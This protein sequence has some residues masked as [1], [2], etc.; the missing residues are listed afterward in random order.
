MADVV[1][2]AVRL[3]TPEPVEPLHSS[4]GKRKR[5]PDSRTPSPHRRRPSPPRRRSPFDRE[6]PLRDGRDDGRLDRYPGSRP[7]MQEK[8]APTE[9]EKAEMAKKEFNELISKRSGGVYIP[10][11]KLR[12]L[13]KNIKDPQSKEYQRMMWDA[14][15]KSINGM[16]N[17]VNVGNIKELVPELFNENLIRGRGLFCRSIM[18]A[19]ASYDEISDV[20]AC[21]VAIVNT[22]LPRV[23]ELLVDRLIW[24]WQRAFKR[25]DKAVCISSSSFLAQLANFEVVDHMVVVQVLLTL[26]KQPTDDSIEIAVRV[27]EKIG[28]LLDDSDRTVANALMNDFRKVLQEKSD[29]AVRTQ[30]QL[31]GLFIKRRN[32]FKD[33]PTRREELD[34]IEDEDV[35]KHPGGF[36]RK[37]IDPQDKL[38][39]FQFDPNWEE[40]EQSYRRLRDE[41]LGIEDDSDEEAGEEDEEGEEEDEEDEEEKKMEIK[42]QTNQDLVNLR[43]SIYL[44][45]K[46]SGTFEEAVHKLM[47]INLPV[48][49]EKE[50]PEMIIECASQERTYNTFYG[51]I[52]E[53]FSKLNRLWRSLN[54]ELF[55]EY[56]ESIHRKDSNKTR[57]IANMFAH[58]LATDSISWSVLECVKMNEDETTAASRIFIRILLEE[59]QSAMGIKQLAERL[60]EPELA[61]Y[62]AEI[63]PMDDPKKTRFAI[64]YFTAIKMG[65]LTEGMREFLASIPKPEPQ[66]L[67]EDSYSDSDRSSSYDRYI[68]FSDRSSSRCMINTNWSSESD[69]RSYSDS[70]DS[71]SRSPRRIRRRSPSSDRSRSPESQRTRDRRDDSR[72]PYRSSDRRRRSPSDYSRSPEPRSRRDDS[73]GPSPRRSN[74]RRRYS[75]SR[76]PSP[77]PRRRGNRDDSRS[78]SPYHSN[79]R[80][81]HSESPSRSRS[82][83]PPPPRRHQ[84]YSSSEPASS[85]SPPPRRRYRSESEEDDRPRARNRRDASEEAPPRGGRARRNS[86]SVEAERRRD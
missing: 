81:R 2:S 50:L 56:Y 31:E 15:K 41:I 43:R 6:L 28:R 10:P 83:S 63:F 49:K 67:E 66:Q 46:S 59:M 3:P 11:A 42:D 62:L 1:A 70:R 17:K 44:T 51:N 19:Q 36:I 27:Y 33:Y 14:L 58:L 64:N 7:Q 23:G 40:T 48:G 84:R 13:Q 22:K 26:L 4:T 12:E 54:E 61:P 34:I 37:K 68:I 73:R 5:A 29:L 21:V 38:N 75:T 82:R 55:K 78:P 77:A 47:R 30:Y 57:I 52:A 74:D 25:N 79:D 45:I 76:S 86:S 65:E 85:R 9:E 35:I 60:Q 16:I 20:L 71:R 8:K 80:R 24:Q 39:V 32:G 69:S 72:S 53:R 18:K